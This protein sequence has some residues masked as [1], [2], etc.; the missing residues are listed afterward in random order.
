MGLRAALVTPLSGRLA[1]FGRAGA[2]ALL[3]WARSAD[4]PASWGRVR[5]DVHDSGPS[6]AKALRS[7]LDG[8]PDLLF[9]PYGSGQAAALARNT[10]RLIW[11][12]G[13]A[14]AGGANVVNVLS[15]ASS[16]FVGALEL[17]R[18]RVRTVTVLHADTGFG[19]EVARGAERHANRLGLAAYRIGFA[20]GTAAEAVGAAPHSDMLLMA[21]GFEDER[22]AGMLLPNR[23]WRACGFVG[24][25]EQDVLAG[26]GEAREG[27]L[28]PAQWLAGCALEPDEGPDADWFVD[29]YTERTGRAPTYPAAQAF[30]AGVIAARCARDAG[31]FDD[32]ALRAAAADLSCTTLYGRFRLDG[33][34]TQTG[35]QVL[36]VQWQDDRRR[37]LWPPELAARGAR[38]RAYGGRPWAGGA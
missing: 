26:L 10:D 29:A 17:L 12:H 36:T 19:R 3:L 30:A 14:T 22:A 2:D 25:G 16:Y 34:G 8:R 7:A 5:L 4:V 13:G 33:S 24:A 20:P 21:A 27:L 37:L 32:D 6:V 15:P 1:G 11:N 9:G 35:H 18:H 23:A 31:G 28:G 38:P